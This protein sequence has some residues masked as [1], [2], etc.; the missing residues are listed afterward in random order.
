M[1][2]TASAPAPT[3]KRRLL[4]AAEVAEWLSVPVSWVRESTRSGAMPCVELG[5]YRRYERAAIEMWLEECRKT[6]KPIALRR[7]EV[8][9]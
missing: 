8:V 5:R 2:R 9:S 1:G 7:R 3:R 4:T 6:G